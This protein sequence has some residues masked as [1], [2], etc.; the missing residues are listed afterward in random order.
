M[1]YTVGG[2]LRSNPF[3]PTVPCHRVIASTL[4][5]GGFYGKWG[6]AA[7]DAPVTTNADG[8]EQGGLRK[9]RTLAEEGVVFRKDGYLEN[10][11]LVWRGDGDDGEHHS[12]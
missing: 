3:A 1:L 4:F 2:A 10:K 9:M 5:I 8:E 11:A 7:G 12:K 6:V